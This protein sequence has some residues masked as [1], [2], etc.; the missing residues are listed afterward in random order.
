M[1]IKKKLMLGILSIAILPLLIVGSIS[2]VEMYRSIKETAG[3]TLLETAEVA[4]SNV[5]SKMDTYEVLLYD[6]G[7]QKEVGSTRYTNDEKIQMIMEKMSVYGF[8]SADIYDKSGKSVLD[9]NSI[10]EDDCYKKAL[11][12]QPAVSN[13]VITGDSIKIDIAAPI[14][15]NGEINGNV[16]G[17][18]VCRMDS[19]LNELV[20]DL[21]VSKNGYAYINDKNGNNIAHPQDDVV[22]S[23]ANNFASIQ[24]D[25]KLKPLLKCTEDMMKGNSGMG[26]YT[27][28]GVHKFVAYAPI[29][30]TDGWSICVV[31]PVND[32]TARVVQSIILIVVLLIVFIVLT[33]LMSMVINKK[34]VVPIIKC[35]KRL[36]LL[37]DGDLHADV[38]VVDTK[39][40]VHDL[41]DA[42]KDIV[43]NLKS[44]IGD[45]DKRLESMANGDLTVKKSVELPGDFNSLNIALDKLFMDWNLTIGKIREA[46]DQV[47]SGAD[48]VSSGAQALSQG[49]TEQASSVQE[50]SATV[51]EISDKIN[52]SASNLRQSNE[53]IIANGSRVEECDGHMQDMMKAMQDIAEAS[54]EINK[55]IKAIDDIAFQTNIL[56]LNAAVEAAR[57]GEAGKG[58]SVVAEEVRTLAQRSAEAVSNT[59]TLIQ[60]SI[61]AV[62]MGTEIADETAKSLA[63]VVDNSAEITNVI[64]NITETTNVQASAA[65][66][67]AQG[68]S[69]ISGVVQSNAATAEE[70]AATSEELTGQANILKNLV[71][72]FKLSDMS[73]IGKDNINTFEDNINS[74][75]NPSVFDNGS[76]D[77]EDDDDKY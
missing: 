72:K 48:Q 20:K 76:L 74:F 21:R 22:I 58:F 13:P 46:A 6:I 4:A 68:I 41:A 39:D 2:V 16:T 5:E 10:G 25:S 33:I 71:S 45:L 40:E 19:F 70:S 69:Q 26:E 43:L 77:F 67:V 42:T 36:K 55:I 1:S 18:I 37:A 65:G 54:K 3:G 52:L 57:A 7:A 73:D 60:N 24:S 8:E 51:N 9:G 47:A 11:Q 53:L 75:D 31:A 30:N 15:E 34:I 27:Y 59:T 23:G 28:K 32:F 61:K 63:V 12:G 49:T 50:L 56:A 35:S 17:V 62:D 44:I 64:S 66:Q 29:N 14:W 38:P